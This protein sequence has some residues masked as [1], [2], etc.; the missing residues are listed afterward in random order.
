M[1]TTPST[2]DSLDTAIATVLTQQTRTDSKAGLLLTLDSILVAGLAAMAN[3]MST[4]AAVVAG[5]A[6]VATVVAAVLA[7]LVT[8]PRLGNGTDRG[9]FVHWATLADDQAVTAVLA[10]DR[11]AAH[12]RVMSRICLTKMRLLQHATDATLLAVGILAVAAVVAALA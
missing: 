3:G 8:R 10:E 7:V 9:S 6:A 2:G 4:P 1:T 5:A 11:R 12:L